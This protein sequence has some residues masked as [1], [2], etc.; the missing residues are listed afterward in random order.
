MFAVGKPYSKTSRVW[1]ELSGT[2]PAARAT[3]KS[4]GASSSISSPLSG[5]LGV[6][7]NP[8][9]RSDHIWMR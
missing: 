5:R 1:L 6:G 8:V 9:W 3:S 4:A 2:L 7:R